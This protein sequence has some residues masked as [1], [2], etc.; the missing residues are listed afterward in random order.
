[1]HL[2]G[3][4]FPHINDDARS[5][6]HQTLFIIFDLTNRLLSS[7]SDSDSENSTEMLND[8]RKALDAEISK[9]KKK[10][11]HKHHHHHKHKK[12]ASS[13]K[14]ERFVQRCQINTQAFVLDKLLK[15]LYQVLLK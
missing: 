13:E 10:K 11:K 15:L 2:V 8:K 1:L 3:I 7:S 6:S 14:P 5:K 12:H 9:K 4:L